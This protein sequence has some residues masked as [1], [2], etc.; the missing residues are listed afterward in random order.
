MKLQLLVQAG[1]ALLVVIIVKLEHQEIAV[2]PM[3]VS[4]SVSH[5][6]FSVYLIL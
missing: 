2:L 6:T 4:L 1:L 5:D 3:V